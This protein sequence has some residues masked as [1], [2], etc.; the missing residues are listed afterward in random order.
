MVYKF[1]INYLNFVIPE[2]FGGD[3]KLR[4]ADV[5]PRTRTLLSAD[6]ACSS[7]GTAR[8]GLEHGPLESF[9]SGSNTIS[10]PPKRLGFGFFFFEYFTIWIITHHRGMTYFFESFFCAY[11]IQISKKFF[12]ATVTFNRKFK[13]FY[14]AY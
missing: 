2:R 6:S 7:R 5:P 14:L 1:L 12:I 13:L 10:S 9:G 4:L 11:R 8:V 3:G